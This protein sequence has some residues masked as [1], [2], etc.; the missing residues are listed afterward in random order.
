MR[1]QHV[2]TEALFAALDRLDRHDADGQTAPLHLPTPLV[3]AL[4]VA[5]LNT[6]ALLR[7][8]VE[9]LAQP[10]ALDAHFEDIGWQPTLADLAVAAAQLDGSPLAE[11][12]E[13]LARAAELVAAIKPD[14]VG[15]DVLLFAAGML[16]GRGDG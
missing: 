11:N 10:P 8:A 7:D 1:K 16:A 2:D 15:E 3:D 4:R 6:A 12:A 5:G 13:L 14:A 9:A